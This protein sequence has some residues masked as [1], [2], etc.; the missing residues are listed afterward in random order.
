[1]RKD[2]RRSVTTVRDWY[3]AIETRSQLDRLPPDAKVRIGEGNPG[4]VGGRGVTA[5]LPA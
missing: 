1:M 5:Q 3:L 2:E 4:E